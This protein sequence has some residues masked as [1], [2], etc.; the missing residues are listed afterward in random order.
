[1]N[2]D[3]RFQKMYEDVK[4]PEYSHEGDSGMDVY[5]RENM[6][7]CGG[8][9]GLLKLGFKVAI[10]CGYEIQVRSKSGLAL[11]EGIV[12]LNSP[13]TVD[14]TYRGEVGVI[15]HNSNIEGNSYQVEKGQ[16]IAQIVLCPVAKCNLKVT[17]SLEETDRGDGGYGS[18]GIK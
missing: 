1:M 6:L 15:L 13:G 4:V 10:P 16:K 12:V 7:I 18:T 14:S 2:I 9:T 8:E 3:V 5:S 11:K 17:D